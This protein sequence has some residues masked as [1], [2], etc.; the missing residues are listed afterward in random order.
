MRK[1]TMKE[2]Y[3]RNITMVRDG[4]NWGVTS[5]ATLSDDIA[6]YLGWGDRAISELAV[7]YANA[8]IAGDDTTEYERMTGLRLRR[9]QG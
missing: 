9:A 6:F 1:M 5:V 3:E 7:A 4:G 2:A 8:F